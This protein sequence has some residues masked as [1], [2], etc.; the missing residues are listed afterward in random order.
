MSGTLLDPGIPD[1]EVTAYRLSIDDSG[2]VTVTLAV[3]RLD[4]EPPQYV[5]RLEIFGGSS[6]RYEL[7]MVFD[8]VHGQ[9][10][11]NRYELLT[12]DGDQPVAVEK[13]WFR[14]VRAIQF[15]GTLARFPR[16]ITPLLGAGVAF[17]GLQFE[18]GA[19]ATIP[20][21]LA[22][23]VHWEL[24]T[25][26]ERVE[27]ISLPVGSRRAWRV[28]VRPSF[29][30]MSKVIDLAIATFLP[31]FVLHFDVDPPHRLLRFSFPTGP[32]RWNPQATVEAVALDA[33]VEGALLHDAR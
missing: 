13:A 3:S 31:A 6:A 11:A 32:F 20:L 15:G 2:G 14:D 18:K 28:S 4:G 8:R 21:Y 27:R 5:Q 16:G 23:T 1:G 24:A 17:R 33:A 30:A 7:E 10:L 22:N 12:F 19:T 29:E 25:K 26:V 9:L